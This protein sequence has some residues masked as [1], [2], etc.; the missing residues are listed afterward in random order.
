MLRLRDGAGFIPPET[1]KLILMR[2]RIRRAYPFAAIAGILLVGVALPFSGVFASKRFHTASANSVNAPQPGPP[3]SEAARLN[4]I[5]VAYMNQQRFAEAQ[6]QFEGALK[7]QPDYALAKLNLGVSLLSQQK[8][9]DAKS[10]AG[11]H[12]KLPQ[13]PY[14]WYNLGLVYKDMANTKR[15]SKR[16]SM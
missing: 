16:S 9:E 14:A 4:S 8:S 11:S 12:G 2:T 13:D 10:F 5:G 6:K 3:L 15:R 7:V 1:G